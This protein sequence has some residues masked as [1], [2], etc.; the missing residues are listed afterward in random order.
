LTPSTSTS[1]I[2]NMVARVQISLP[3]FMATRKKAIN[4]VLY[5]KSEETIV[6]YLV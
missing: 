6:S 3:I 5:T 4:S 1:V 2:S